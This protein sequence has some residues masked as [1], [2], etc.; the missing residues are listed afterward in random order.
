M[1]H[2]GRF[3]KPLVRRSMDAA[4]RVSRRGLPTAHARHAEA[5]EFLAEL[6][7]VADAPRL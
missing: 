6:Q 3:G 1:K 7:G 4:A 5:C 2:N